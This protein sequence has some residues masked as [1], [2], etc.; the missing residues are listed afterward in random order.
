[1]MPPKTMLISNPGN[2]DSTATVRAGI[3]LQPLVTS[4]RACGPA[5]RIRE[6]ARTLVGI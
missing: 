5:N 1:M 2:A 3:R 4:P 6:P